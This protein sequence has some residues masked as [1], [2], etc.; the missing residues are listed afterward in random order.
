VHLVS[1]RPE[2]SACVMPSKLYGIFAAGTP[3]IALIE[4]ET[5]L[6]ELINDHAVGFT[7][8]PNDDVSLAERI[9]ELAAD[10]DLVQTL[11]HNARRLAEREFNRRRQTAR[12][13]AMLCRVLGQPVPAMIEERLSSHAPVT[14]EVS[15]GSRSV[16]LDPISDTTLRPLGLSTAIPHSIH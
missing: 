5:E 8:S 15:T 6:H 12:F 9:Q 13:A 10:S 2:A 3:T 14:V 7:C 1:V 4:P 16:T 11:G